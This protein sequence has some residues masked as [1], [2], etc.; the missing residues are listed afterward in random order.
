MRSNRLL[1]PLRS[2][3]FAKRLPA[4]LAALVASALL[5][6]LL[7]GC[8]AVIIIK[9][10][11]TY[12]AV[13]EN[14]FFECETFAVCTEQE[15]GPH[16]YHDR[17]CDHFTSPGIVFPWDVEDELRD[18]FEDAVPDAIADG[19]MFGVNA[20][21]TDL[22][23]VVCG[24]PFGIVLNPATSGAVLYTVPF[25]TFLADL[26]LQTGP[27]CATDDPP[28]GVTLN[29]G[30]VWINLDCAITEGLIPEIDFAMLPSA[31]FIGAVDPD[32]IDDYLDCARDEAV[33][34]ATTYVV[35]LIISLVKKDGGALAAETRYIYAG[36]VGDR[37]DSVTA[38]T[39]RDSVD[40]IP[41]VNA[42]PGMV[43]AFKSICNV[44]PDLSVAVMHSEIKIGG[45]DGTNFEVT[46]QAHGTPLGGADLQVTAWT[47][48]NLMDLTAIECTL[49]FALEPRVPFQVV[50]EE[51]KNTHQ[52]VHEYVDVTLHNGTDALGGFDFLIAYDASAIG[53]QSVI[54][55]PAFYDPVPNGCGWEYFSYRYG[56]FGNCGDACPS[57][58]VRVFGLAETNNGPN[59]PDCFLP[60]SLPAVLFTLDFLVSNDRTLECQ[61]VPINFFWLDCGDNVISSELGDSLYVSQQVFGPPGTGTAG[62]D[63][64][65]SVL[66]DEYPD[67]VF[68]T[69]CGFPDS[70]L[71]DTVEGKPAPERFIMFYNGGVDIIC[72]D[73]IDDRGD[74][75][76]NGT[77]NEIADAVLFSNYF[78]H[79]ISVFNVNIDGQI[80]ASDVNADGITLSVADL[81]YQIRIIVGD[82]LP[83]PKLSPVTAD[84]DLVDGVLSVNTEMGAAYVVVE[85]SMTPL[86]LAELME[87]KYHYDE[88][89][90]LTRILVYS[91]E[92]DRRFSGDFLG[93]IDGNVMTLEMAT[94]EGAPVTTK[95]VPDA[96]AL[97][98]CYP[99]PF[100]PITTISFALAAPVDYELVIYNALG[101]TVE[102]FSG[103]SGPG[104]E[105]IDWDASALASGVYFYRLT[106]GD[107]NDTKKMVLLK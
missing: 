51:T 105:R 87:M 99:N 103:R 70:C 25:Q 10:L 64:Q 68:P 88:G 9:I 42:D 91:M 55:G 36:V 31:D 7:S 30:E 90:N 2:P 14:C 58:M 73:S 74:I 32:L 78:V 11:G 26:D 20:T 40:S 6:F 54:E 59:H 97:Y 93:G 76:L 38:W 41:M 17:L 92:P 60:D 98:P 86:L 23:N 29:P 12:V 83:Y 94:Y 63:H 15:F 34:C 62:F 107:F 61:F 24:T 35:G 81:V 18:A 13:I 69:F 21:H 22:Q 56:P 104:L 16:F 27:N 106:A 101:Q 96:F 33:K 72:A 43:D 82:A 65:R 28:P 67:P 8:V 39:I 80:A 46:T 71:A 1:W 100:N 50:V 66:T 5:V 44:P 75:N 89:N 85:N 48:E 57:G 52:G 95:L 45:K 4:A 53:L 79:G 49:T 84:A 19:Y 37:F 47:A 102:T 3:T 77:A